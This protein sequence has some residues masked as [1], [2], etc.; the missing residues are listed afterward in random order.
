[1][2]SVKAAVAA[3]VVIVIVIAAAGVALTYG[4]GGNDSGN[5]NSGDTP[6]V[7]A[8]GTT[9]EV[10][11][12]YTLASS[13]T[14]GTLGAGE[15]NTSYTVTEVNGDMVRVQVKSGNNTSYETMSTQDFLDDI[16]VVNDQYI[17][18]YERTEIITTPMGD[19]ECM[20]YV[21]TQDV[22]NAVTVSTQDWIG[23][24]SNIIYQTV[25]T[26]TST[27]SNEVYTTNLVSTNMI[28]EGTTP[29]TNVP[30]PPVADTTIRTDLQSGDYVEYSKYEDDGDRDYER[31]TVISI[32]DG[33]VTYRDGDD[34]ERCSIDEFMGLI[35]YNPGSGTLVTTET[36]NTMFGNI[37]CNV[38]EMDQFF[39]GFLDFDLE[40]R[41]M[42]WASVDDN[43]IYKIESEEYYD[44][45]HWGDWH[46]DRESYYLTG[47]SL[48][49]ATGGGTVVDPTPTPQSNRFGIELNENDTFTIRDDNGRD[50]E[51]YTIVA[52][53]GNYLTV[54]ET[55]TYDRTEIERMSA[56]EFLGKFMITADQLSR[57]YQSTN[58][59]EVVNG[60]TC[61]VYTEMFDDDRETIYVQQ[62]GSNYIVWQKT[63]DRYDTEI[64]VSYSI[65]SL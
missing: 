61:Q 49:D 13:Y 20:I 12:S 51:T 15:T 21:D 6:V 40:D 7:D 33:M 29:G 58:Q 27:A 59:T 37:Q 52:V 64:L 26:I 35:V 16:S 5:G 23:V 14:D 65:A 57:G 60:V 62:S 34:R 50:T 31:Y 10:N 42:V 32:S 55:G 45:D 4:G 17:G 9:V 43:V 63:E 24:G 48:M 1:M 54:R 25:I 41:V 36:I 28:Q 8:I 44:D 2:T 11:N 53:E 30:I 46:D 47:T 56:N 19:R 38:Y 39:R 22:G 3:V 18:S